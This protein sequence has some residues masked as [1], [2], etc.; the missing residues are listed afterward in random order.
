M[1]TITRIEFAHVTKLSK[2]EYAIRD[3]NF[4]VEEKTIYALYGRDRAAQQAVMQMTA[5]LLLPDSGEV[6][7]SGENLQGRKK[8]LLRQVGY[9]PQ[10]TAGYPNLSVEENL[11][12]LEHLRPRHRDEMTEKVMEQMKLC[13]GRK[14]KAGRLEPE[15]KK[16]LGLAM[17]LLHD[18][19]ILILND[20]FSGLD[21]A[22]VKEISSLFRNLCREYEKTVF[23]CCSDL[24][25][26]EKLADCI[27]YMEQGSLIHEF[28]VQE[29]EEINRQYIC[30][31]SE[32]ISDMIPL[33]ERVLHI[34]FYDVTDENT[35]RI[36]DPEL[37]SGEI[38]RC[39]LEN[40]IGVK[41]IFRH[42]GTLQEHL[43]EISRRYRGD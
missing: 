30:I 41:E 16:R 32:H 24:G 31:V 6:R 43:N 34:R 39:L 8:I 13:E 36:Y 29:R 15:Q 17:A 4:K 20:P 33:M 38:N 25:E 27:G 14:Q 35:L 28:S 10:M 40:G 2:N 5:G 23:M 26:V 19:E 12:L 3:L 21:T 9:L 11:K 18:P 1:G 37:N 22:G 42:T 7:V